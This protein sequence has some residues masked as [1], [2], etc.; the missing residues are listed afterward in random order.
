VLEDERTAWTP[1]G[2]KSI[3]DMN[4]IEALQLDYDQQAIDRSEYEK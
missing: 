4:V 3:D 1:E 2:N